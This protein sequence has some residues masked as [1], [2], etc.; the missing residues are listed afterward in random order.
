MS[1]WIIGIA[2]IGFLLIIPLFFG[3][4]IG[5]NYRILGNYVVAGLVLIG[6]VLVISNWHGI[7]AATP[8]HLIGSQATQQHIA[9][10]AAPTAHPAHAKTVTSLRPAPARSEHAHSAARSVQTAKAENTFLQGIVQGVAN[11]VIV[12]VVVGIIILLVL[13]FLARR[14]KDE[15]EE[16]EPVRVECGKCGKLGNHR[17]YNFR[18]GGQRLAGYLCQLC[19][20]RSHA[21][22]AAPVAAG[23]QQ[24]GV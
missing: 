21:S 10:H 13:L 16:Q 24:K 9:A 18:H 17:V 15:A 3:R 8:L 11:T 5:R 1:N 22:L 14:K 2:A 4:D 19:A 20:R 23:K 6:V 12:M 7:V